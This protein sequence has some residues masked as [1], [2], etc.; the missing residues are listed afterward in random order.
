VP[1]YC[2]QCQKC[3]LEIEVQHGVDDRVDY[4]SCGGKLKRLL[5]AVAGWMR[6]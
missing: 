5:Y 1:T 4:C 3:G 2:Y 6:G